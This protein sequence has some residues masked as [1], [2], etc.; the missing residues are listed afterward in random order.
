M[1]Y[2]PD[3][4]P[5]LA[6]PNGRWPA[7]DWVSG[8][9]LACNAD[10]LVTMPSSQRGEYASCVGWGH[11]TYQH[12]F[13]F[14]AQVGARRLITFHHDPSHDDDMLDQLLEDSDP[15]ASR[16]PVWQLLAERALCSASK[17]PFSPSS[18]REIALVGARTAVEHS[19]N[20]AHGRGSR[21]C[22]RQIDGSISPDDSPT[23]R[24]GRNH[25]IWPA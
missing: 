24:I 10:L 23:N 11:S 4:E 22:R 2:L 12:A 7:P 19:K 25:E 20:L 16:C 5:A 18:M 14:A 8:Y 9:D 13:E 21:R 17:L 15:V 3:H 6:L 1:A